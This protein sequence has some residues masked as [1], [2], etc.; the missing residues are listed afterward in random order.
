MRHSALFSCASF[1][2][3]AI[4]AGNVA[5]SLGFWRDLRRY[6]IAIIEKMT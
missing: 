3:A 4:A 2:D 1:R 6:R 5:E